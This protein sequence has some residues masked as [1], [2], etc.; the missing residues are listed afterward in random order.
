[1]AWN[2]GCGDVRLSLPE[3]FG[4]R[5]IPATRAAVKRFLGSKRARCDDVST[6]PRGASAATGLKFCRQFIVERRAQWLSI[7]TISW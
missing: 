1:M 5:F 7:W 3:N 6:R 4:R 2:R